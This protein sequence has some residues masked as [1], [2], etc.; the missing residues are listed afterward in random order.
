MSPTSAAKK[1]LSVPVGGTGLCPEAQAD[2]VPC[3]AL[4]RD[5]EVCERASDWQE[6]TERYP[7]PLEKTP[8]SLKPRR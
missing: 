5:C 1:S 2:G 6:A 3:T 4:G 7:S 8:P